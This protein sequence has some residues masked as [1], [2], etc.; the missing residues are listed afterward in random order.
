MVVIVVVDVSKEL[1][2]MQRDKR[3]QESE[4]R[5]TNGKRL[6][7]RRPKKLKTQRTLIKQLTY[8]EDKICHH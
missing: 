2:N 8:N 7:R 3:L 5:R 4:L 1:G 6:K